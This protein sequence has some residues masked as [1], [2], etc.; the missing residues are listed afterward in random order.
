MSQFISRSRIDVT[1]NA[2]WQV[3]GN[4]PTT[5][6]RALE[7]TAAQIGPP[8]DPSYV[9]P[10]LRRSARAAAQKKEHAAAQQAANKLRDRQQREQVMAAKRALFTELARVY[11]VTNMS[12]RLLGQFLFVAGTCYVNPKVRMQKIEEL[13]ARHKRDIVRPGPTASVSRD[14][15][16]AKFL[17]DLDFMTKNTFGAISYGQLSARGV[18][19]EEAMKTAKTTQGLMDFAGGVAGIRDAPAPHQPSRSNRTGTYIQPH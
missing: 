1:F 9:P 10:P 16:V 12:D 7:R 6:S 15:Q 2:W 14:K 19:H 13:V 11:G 5:I 4:K 8:M 18:S 17:A 3:Y